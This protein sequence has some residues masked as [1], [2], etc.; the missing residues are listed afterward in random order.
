MGTEHWSRARVSDLWMDINHNKI[1]N[2]NERL[3]SS[4]TSSCWVKEQT[5]IAPGIFIVLFWD[6]WILLCYM[7]LPV[8]CHFLWI[9]LCADVIGQ[10]PQTKFSY[11][12]LPLMPVVKSVITFRLSVFN[13][14]KCLIS[15]KE[16]QVSAP[17]FQLFEFIDRKDDKRTIHVSEESS[18]AKWTSIHANF[19]MVKNRPHCI[20]EFE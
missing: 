2:C 17:H 6:Q 16:C 12:V 13:V 19:V 4:K 11:I 14:F 15:S 10:T 1:L 7:L 3:C 20:R 18:T 8:I 9:L 5:H